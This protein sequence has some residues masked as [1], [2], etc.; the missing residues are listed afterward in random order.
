MIRRPPRSTLSSS[1][2]ASDVYKRQS[3]TDEHFSTMVGSTT[4]SEPMPNAAEM[5]E[6]REDLQAF[7]EER[8]RAGESA[9]VSDVVRDAMEQKKLAVLREALDLGI[10]ELDAG[11]GVETTPDELMAEISAELGLDQ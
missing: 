3:L 8:V 1:S 7:A 11:L 6:L 4:T 10:A 5:I 9:S 2:A